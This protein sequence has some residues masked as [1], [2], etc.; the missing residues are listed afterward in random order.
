MEHNITSL[1]DI[2]L[3][4]DDVKIL[5]RCISIWKS[6]PAGKPHEIWSLDM[7]FQDEI[8]SLGTPVLQ[9]LSA[10]TKTPVVKFEPFSNFFN[11][12]FKETDVVDVIGT[13]VSI[14]DP[15]PFNKDGEDKIRRNVIL[16]DFDGKQ[17]E[18]CFSYEWADKFTKYAEN[19]ESLIHVVMILQPARKPYVRPG[20]FA[21]KVFI[22]EKIPEIEAFRQR[23]AE[24]PGYDPTKHTITVFS[25]A[26]KI[27]NPFEFLEGAFKKM[28]GN[29]CDSTNDLQQKYPDALTNLRLLTDYGATVLHGVD[30]RKMSEHP[31]LRGRTYD[32]IIYNF[33]HAGFIGD[34]STQAVIK[35]NGWA[36]LGC[37]RCGSAAKEIDGT[38]SSSGSKFKKQK[39]WKCK[40]HDEITSLMTM[41]TL[42]IIIPVTCRY[43]VN[44]R[45]IDDT[46]SASLLLFDDFVFKLTG[47]YCQALINQYG[48]Q[49]ED[50]LPDELNTMIEV[51]ELINEFGPEGYNIVYD[52]FGSSQRKLRN[53]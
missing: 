49:H 22:N 42:C 21:T 29:I 34:E 2:D 33:P 9:G 35:E 19:H 4:L 53:N 45:V 32:F 17:L 36:Y 15:V 10:G 51:D 48:E 24:I 31:R 14:T 30:A 8:L 7:I 1:C 38:A 23:Y 40:Q 27:I 25:P 52:F 47:V 6:H 3:M 39:T 13:I 44:I 46:G 12:E 37:K 41:Y 20:L 50:Y 16:E 26:K 18:L 28:V 5:A 43:K 11:K